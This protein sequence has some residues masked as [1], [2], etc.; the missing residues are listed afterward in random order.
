MILEQSTYIL[1]AFFWLKDNE[2]RQPF[3]LSFV[4]PL[5]MMTG[6]GLSH[7]TAGNFPNPSETNRENHHE[8]FGA[9]IM[10]FGNEYFKL[11]SQL[12]FPGQK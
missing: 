3:T 11:L 9:S 7:N 5:S 4:T 2:N 12:S 10:S 8:H 1:K 6:C